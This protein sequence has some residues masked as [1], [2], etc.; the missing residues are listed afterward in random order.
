MAALILPQWSGGSFHQKWRVSTYWDGKGRK[1]RMHGTVSGIRNFCL[2]R[3]DFHGLKR[4]VSALI[5]AGET[6]INR[7][8]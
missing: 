1:S 5:S 8:L 2:C 7:Q 3:L 4:R 6:T